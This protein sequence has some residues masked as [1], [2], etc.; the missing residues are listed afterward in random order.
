[1]VDG[2][3]TAIDYFSAHEGYFWHW[4]EHGRVIEFA[5]KH[6]ICYREDLT[7]LLDKLPGE[8]RF[9]L[10]SILLLLCAC[11]DGWESNFEAEQQLMR[12]SVVQGFT[13]ANYAAAA[14][15]KNSAYAFLKIVNSLPAAER[16]GL[17]RTALISDIAATIGND[18][19]LPEIHSM[20]RQ[21]NTGE[22]DHAVLQNK[23]EL[24]FGTIQRDLAP[25]AKAL[26][27]LPDKETLELKLKTGLLNVPKK[28]EIPRPDDEGTDLLGQ[29]EQDNQT[30]VLSN[31]VRK[32]LVAIRIPMDLSGSSDYALGGVAD[33]SN[34]GNYDQLLLSELAQD[35][36]LLTARL[37]NN[38]ALFLQ[39]EIPPDKA[40]QELGIFIDMSLKM[41]GMPRVLAIA[42]GLA[43]RESKLKNQQLKTWGL[44]EKAIALDLNS[45]KGV[46]A[47]LSVLDPALN[48][49][50]QLVKVIKEQRKKD[51]KYI[52]ITGDD[53]L[54]NPATA[55]CFHR[56][57]EQLNFLVAVSRNGHVKMIRLTKGHQ[58][59]MNEANITPDDLVYH[60]VKN[61]KR[62]D[63][64]DDL[65]AIILMEEFP[66]YYPTSK[67]KISQHNT[68]VNYG[69]D[70]RDPEVKDVVIITQDNRVLCWRD[71]NAGAIELIEC[72][73]P[74]Q[75]CFGQKDTNVYLAAHPHK[76]IKLYDLKIDEG[77]ADLYDIESEHGT[78]SGIKYINDKFYLKSA[79]GLQI[80][81][82]ETMKIIPN[83]K[84]SES[85]FNYQQPVRYYKNIAPLKKTINIGYSV[86][87]S[88]KSI[89]LYRGY[90]LVLDKHE[91]NVTERGFNWWPFSREEGEYS[92]P[93][94]VTRVSVKHL[95]NIWF[96]KFTW[97]SGSTIIMDS[98]GMLHLK[99]AN[100][101][102]PEVTILLVTEK[103]AAC[104]SAD[105]VVSGLKYF[106]GK[107]DAPQ[108]E[109]TVFFKN[110]IRPFLATLY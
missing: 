25:L 7:Y 100:G 60:P 20:V 64:G 93:G 103:P 26:R 32:L 88:V 89:K 86:I 76:A 98:R 95:P 46:I 72:L 39:R 92:S 31:L 44:G 3:T 45:K 50:E 54:T 14:Q 84:W 85:S 12:V 81:S 83:E 43:F 10:G 65:P 36:I 66:L 82:L 18:A 69:K 19:S 106:T 41:W 23:K 75:S 1:M 109:P 28:I 91:L 35:E 4:A 67:V 94:Q 30:R 104:W 24:S 62:T 80:L 53:F 110:Y 99:A 59:L 78:A 105:G 52:L 56:I 17:R 2:I 8:V 101:N 107:T 42:A 58:H 68:Y 11:K 40:E 48:C 9:P 63:L 74:G 102:I 70:G 27:L 33:I 5:N 47:A 15:M 71:S 38:E 55:A 6:T 34:R 77:I 49:A 16:I 57:R 61:T 13:S 22:L 90:R 21:L 51:G 87:N 79:D 108:M 37:A 96:Q 29:L 73:P 97:K